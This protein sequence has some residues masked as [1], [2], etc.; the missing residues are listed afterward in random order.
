MDINRESN[1]LEL[2]CR[3]LRDKLENEW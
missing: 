1:D 3:A 2:Y